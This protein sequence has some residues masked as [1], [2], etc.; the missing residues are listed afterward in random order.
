MEP[1]LFILRRVLKHLS[2]LPVIPVVAPRSAGERN[3]LYINRSK[4]G[5]F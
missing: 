3:L 1:P 5:G 4:R 2:V